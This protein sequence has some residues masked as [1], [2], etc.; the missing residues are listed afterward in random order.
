MGTPDA[1]T[2]AGLMPGL[3]ADL[4]RLV[5]IPSVSEWGFPEHTQSALLECHDAVVEMLASAGVQNIG[6]LELEGTAPVITGEIPGPPGAPTVLLYSHY[7]VVPAG[8]EAEWLTPP[9]EAVEKDGAIYGRGT[10]DTKANILVHVGALRA[11]G[12][13]PPVGIKVLIEGQ[14]EVGSPM[15][16]DYPAAN[17]EPFSA[18]AIIVADGGSIRAGQPSLTVSLR[19]DARVTVEVQTLASNKHSGQYGGAAPDALVVLLKAIASLYEDNGDL[20]VDGLRREEWDGESYTDEEFRRLAEIGEGMP[21]VGTGSIGSR[22]WALGGMAAAAGPVVGGL[23]VQIDWRLVFLVNLPVGIVGLVYGTR[24]LVE[25]R[26]EHASRPDLLGAAAFT[27]ATG[28][29]VLAIV[30]GEDWGWLSPAT[31]GLF[32]T[33]VLAIAAVVA[34]SASHATP[35]FEPD[36]FKARSFS[37]AV[38]G[39]IAFYAGFAAMLLGGVLFLTTVW[40]EDVLTAGLMLAPGPAMAAVFSVI[41]SRIASRVGFRLPGLIGTLLFSAS[42]LWWALRVGDTPDF[43]GDFLPG[44]VVGGIGVGFTIPILTGAGASSL[45]PQRFATGVAIVTMGRQVGSAIGVAIL[46]AVLGATAVTAA[47]FRA[48]WWIV[49]GGGVLAAVAIAALG[50]PRTEQATQL[51]AEVVA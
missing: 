14:E 28:A 15:E 11:W 12:G 42:A 18:D 17:P 43:A 23:L 35:I 24:L 16:D 7:D 25:R 21:I 20:A 49:I 5:A 30:E 3:K 44:M 47:D 37:L 46:V 38:V 9:F 10:A 48:A 2:V 22:I 51:G 40:R 13:K 32:A 4:S 29:L 50:P 8:D 26:E 34:R 1:Q 36:L 19:G 27:A 31:I 45:P 6:A 39:S 41:S 33:S